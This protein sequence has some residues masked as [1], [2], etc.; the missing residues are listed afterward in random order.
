VN[1]KI[2]DDLGGGALSGA[3]AGSSVNSLVE[4]LQVVVLAQT[5]FLDDV[6]A[7]TVA[8][9]T[10]PATLQTEVDDSF[11]ELTPET[12]E[13]LTGSGLD[14]FTGTTG[15]EI[16]DQEV[17]DSL[18]ASG[19]DAEFEEIKL[20]DTALD[21]SDLDSGVVVVDPGTY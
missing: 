5:T 21:T 17:L 11:I 16:T 3:L 10:D 1:A 6:A 8:G 9:Y 14:D 13:F 2:E 18:V 4:T 20:D 19:D 15:I 7:G 12:L